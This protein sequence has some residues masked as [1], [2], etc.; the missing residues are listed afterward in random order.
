M[1][2]L[3]TFYGSPVSSYAENKLE[4]AGIGTLLAVSRQ[5]GLNELACVRFA[6]EF[7]RDNV[8]IVTNTREAGHEKHLVSGES[9]GRV[10]FGGEQSIDE[11]LRVVKDG[12]TVNNTELSDEFGY[13]AYRDKYPDG[14]VLFG[15][16]P[17]GKLRFPVDDEAL[18]PTGGWQIAALRMPEADA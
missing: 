16:D 10:L 15:I 9:S 17:A 12:A 7:G 6:E 13:D 3:S 2:G 18:E 11:L 14:I 8:F 4:L 5:P 1:L